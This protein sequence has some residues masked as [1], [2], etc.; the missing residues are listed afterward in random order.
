M[1]KTVIKRDGRV[2]D[3]SAEKLN[4]WGHWASKTLGHY[5]DWPTVVLD[6]VAR[7]PEVCTTE[8]LQETLIRSCLDRSSWSYNRMAGRLYAS[9]IH[10]KLYGGRIPTV[11]ELHIKLV[12]IGVM[13][14]LDYS[15]EEYQQVE[16]MI[17]HKRDFK[18]AYFEIHQCLNKYSLQN[19]VT[20]EKYESQQFVYMRMAMAIFEDEPKENRMKHVEKFYEHLSMKRIN[21][22]TP[23]FINLGTHMRGLSSCCLYTVGD[24]AESLAIGDHIAYTM[25]YASAGIG[26]HINTRS[27][28]DPVRNGLIEHQGKLPYFRSLVGAVKANLQSGRGGAC[29]TH[30]SIFDPEIKT[31]LKLKNT[32]S[33]EDKKIRGIDYSFGTNRFFAKKAAKKED[34][35]LFNVFTAPDLVEA[36]YSDDISNFE[37]IY[38]KYENDP[39]FKKE[40][41]NARDILITLLNEQYE[42]GRTYEH[43]PEEMNRHTPFLDTIYSSNLCVA[44]ETKILTDKGDVV[45][46]EVV[47]QK[48]NVWN[49]EEWSEVVPMKTGTHKSLIRVQTK[50]G[51]V[52]HCTPYH[53]FYM[54]DG[55]ITR[56]GLLLSG[57]VLID[58]EIIF[59][60]VDEGRYDDTY[61]F[62][63]PKKGMGVF[64]DILTGN[65][66]EI[67]LPTKP[68]TNMMDLY[69]DELRHSG[70]VGICS[71]GGIVP[72]N[73]DSDEMYEEVAYYT[74]LMIDKCIDL[75]E[76][77]L[78]HVGATARARR[79]AGIGLIGLAHYMAKNK[80]SFMNEE[81]K[82]FLHE[83]AEKHYYYC[84]KASLKIGKEKGNAEWIHK[85]KW[86][87]GWLPIDT[88]N[89]NIDSVADFEYKKDWE[90]LRKEI[91]EN[92]GIR[93]SVIVAHMPSESSSQASGTTNGIYPIREL[94]MIKTDN[95]KAADWAAPEGEKLAKYYESVW[96]IPAID[97]THMYAI[98]QK[99]TDQAISADSFRYIPEGENI[100]SDEMIRDYLNRIKFGLKTK[101]Y[102]NSRITDNGME[103]NEEEITEDISDTESDE[104]C[105][106]CAL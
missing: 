82:K 49:G 6:T 67:A 51:K 22:P 47:G 48:V 68:Y 45:I 21:A 57:D 61:C 50:S 62:T 17:D 52:L 86:P 43:N 94:A 56:A 65:C 93:N 19:R 35:F 53:K 24:S 13:K 12:D 26:S 32:K 60:V 101:Y 4:Q 104:Y 31:I 87:R 39:D 63:E 84:L 1:I 40:Y 28:G 79:S 76:H 78:P 81:G 59:S 70:E 98:I 9:L 90:S 3:F 74:L 102:T 91:I 44:P 38:L 73:I 25:T 30:V 103:K 75:A 96:D 7:L 85:T 10:K 14:E 106:S 58:S 71:L 83:L 29:T 69:S 46:S 23:Y 20:K 64:N 42:T 27:L 5:V 97:I 89:K 37:K 66:Q 18:S 95:G 54:K 88:Y 72:S 16:R 36:F 41:V 8:N 33:T 2:E 15:D 11:R 92:G 100:T 80:M 55:N 77:P 105:E 99:F 34:V